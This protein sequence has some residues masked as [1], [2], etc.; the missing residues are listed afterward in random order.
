MD[1]QLQL[2]LS[3]DSPTKV[4][5]L[6]AVIQTTSSVPIRAARRP[7]MM[8][9]QRPQGNRPRPPLAVRQSAARLLLS[10][11]RA[12]REY[13]PPVPRYDE[14]PGRVCR[15]ISRWASPPKS[16]QATRCRI[17]PATASRRVLFAP[18]PLQLRRNP[19]RALHATTSLR[20]QC[21]LSRCRCDRSSSCRGG[22]RP[23]PEF[24]EICARAGTSPA[25]T[26]HESSLPPPNTDR[27]SCSQPPP[28]G[29]RVSPTLS[30][31]LT[32]GPANGRAT[33]PG[34][35]NAQLPAGARRSRRSSV[36]TRDIDRW[37]TQAVRCPCFQSRWS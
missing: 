29:R 20:H 7:S 25:P 8:D 15:E 30:F 22:A 31:H 21:H 9:E 23:R 1:Y 10:S 6:D 5:T 13:R 16:V 18:R 19:H 26:F 33:T 35:A 37:P 14:F 3:N 36:V 12:R 11:S 32:L 28:Q 24:Y 27:A 2:G 17:R 4:G 34:F